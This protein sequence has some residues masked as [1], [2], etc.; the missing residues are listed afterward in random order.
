MEIPARYD[1]IIFHPLDREHLNQIVRIQLQ[2]LIDRLAQRDLTLTVSDA[3]C[4]VLADAGYDPAFGARPLKRAI[5]HLLE[6]PL[7]LALVNG[8]FEDASQITVDV[9]AEAAGP[10]LTFR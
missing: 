6:D 4:T 9:D 8:D 7:A 10:A 1:Q 2:R 5:T 3:A